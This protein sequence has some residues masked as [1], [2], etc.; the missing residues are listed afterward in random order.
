LR[1]SC[2]C[3]AGRDH[4][5]AVPC[6]QLLNINGFF[7]W[8]TFSVPLCIY[9]AAITLGFGWI[10]ERE[11]VQSLFGRAKFLYQKGKIARAAFEQQATCLKTLFSAPG[12]CGSQAGFGP[13]QATREGAGTNAFPRRLARL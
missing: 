8:I 10:F 11:T 9:A 2:G 3:S 6:V 13:R 5:G 12:C 4:R 7:K 1:A